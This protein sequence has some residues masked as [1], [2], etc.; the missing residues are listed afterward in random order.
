LTKTCT[1]CGET[2][3]LSEFNNRKSAKDGKRSQCR[4]CEN[5]YKRQW[6][7]ANPDKVKAYS[8][9][10]YAEHAEERRAY[11]RGFYWGNI[12]V[13][14]VAKKPYSAAYYAANAESIKAYQRE[15]RLNNLEAIELREAAYRLAHADELKVKKREWARNNPEKARAPKQ[16]YTARKRE[17]VVEVFTGAELIQ[18]WIDNGIDPDHCIYC[19]GPHEHDDHVIPLARGGTHERAN[20]VPACKRCNCSKKDKFLNEWRP[21]MFTTISL[22]GE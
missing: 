17:A 4:K 19:G 7:A 14:K 9:A 6:D 15:Y 11:S 5:E 8:K 21:D 22:G 1:K 13:I 18:Y 16:R 10:Y 2:K 3:P 12:D 20:L